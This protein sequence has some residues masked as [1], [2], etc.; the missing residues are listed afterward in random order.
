MKTMIFPGIVFFLTWFVY[1]TLPGNFLDGGKYFKTIAESNQSIISSAT[2]DFVK[3]VNQLSAKDD[4]TFTLKSYLSNPGIKTIYFHAPEF[5]RLQLNGDVNITPGKKLSF[6]GSVVLTGKARIN[7]GIIEAPYDRQLFDTTVSLININVSGK[8]FPATWYGLKNNERR[9]DKI[10]QKSMEAAGKRMPVFIPG[11]KYFFSH[12]LVVSSSL[13]GEY[14][15]TTLQSIADT[16]VE[17]MVM[18]QIVKDSV[19][20]KNLNLDGNGRVIWV[21]EIL[22]NKTN[23]EISGCKIGGAAQSASTRIQVAGIRFRDGM[24]YLHIHDC[25]FSDINA[26]VT[27]V[28]RGILG[29]GKVSPKHVII[30]NNTFDGITSIG[31]SNWDADQIVIQDYRDSSGMIIRYNRHLNISKRGQK[32]QSPGLISYKNEFQSSR[33]RT[34][35]KRSY[36]SISAYADGIVISDNTVTEGVYENCIEVGAVIG[37]SFNNICIVSNK[38]LLSETKLGNNDG[39]RIYGSD[40]TGLI[41]RKN[42]ICNVRKGIWLDCSSRGSV[43]DSNEVYNCTDN[44]YCVDPMYNKWP[45]TWN[46]DVTVTNNRAE[47]VFTSSAFY[48]NRISGAIIS[49]NRAEHVSSLGI[50][51][52]KIDSLR[53]KI[54]IEKNI[55]PTR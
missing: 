8:Y 15:N 49:G 25:I 10:L 2:V 33:Y 48:F 36:A 26:G 35:G 38:L 40:N 37:E 24:D 54:I 22:N 7:G 29:S 13:T 53:G 42:Y 34:D 45:D 30:E 1:H 32:L 39:I 4:V 55:A 3:V 17:Q 27:G 5:T 19:S 12:P 46:S 51:L 6:D 41:I 43:I 44:A 11:G 47:N 18:M 14:G 23:V 52:K 50:D 31:A 9:A 21:M 20:V 16:A 28:A